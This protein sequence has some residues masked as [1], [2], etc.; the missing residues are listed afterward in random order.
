MSVPWDG[1]RGCCALLAVGGQYRTGC[2][3]PVLPAL[4]A[5]GEGKHGYKPYSLVIPKSC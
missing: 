4:Y 3:T 2:S 1:S 5:S